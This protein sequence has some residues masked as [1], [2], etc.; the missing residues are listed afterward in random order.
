MRVVKEQVYFE[1]IE[2]NDLNEVMDSVIINVVILVEVRD[3]IFEEMNVKVDFTKVHNIVKQ[4][5][6]TNVNL[7]IN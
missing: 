7:K 6:F 4:I 3:D 1:K 5:N 2:G